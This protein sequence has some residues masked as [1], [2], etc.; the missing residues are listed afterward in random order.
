MTLE[1]DRPLDGHANGDRNG[2]LQKYFLTQNVPL[3][4]AT[5]YILSSR[6]MSQLF[7]GVDFVYRSVELY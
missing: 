6:K 7:N 5:C 2:K 1:D 3:C 4:G